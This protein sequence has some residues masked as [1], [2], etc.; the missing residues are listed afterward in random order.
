MATRI[1]PPCW[2]CFVEGSGR[3]KRG[4]PTIEVARAE[5]IRLSGIAPGKAVW[6]FAAV[7]KID[8]VPEVSPSGREILHIKK[9]A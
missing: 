9:K 4:H 8:P 5:A 7:E 6:I 3:P 2:L 1:N